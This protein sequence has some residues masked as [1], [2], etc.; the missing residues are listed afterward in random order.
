MN[1]P[2]QNGR[3]YGS[4]LTLQKL[5]SILETSSNFSTDALVVVNRLTEESILD[6]VT[7]LMENGMFWEIFQTTEY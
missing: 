6:A 1:I 4:F 7:G 3:F 2:L 5:A